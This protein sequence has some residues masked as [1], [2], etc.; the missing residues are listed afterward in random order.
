MDHPILI[1]VIKENHRDD[2][3]VV[4]KGV[5]VQEREHVLKPLSVI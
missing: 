3:Q 4:E 5:E 1:S 2:K